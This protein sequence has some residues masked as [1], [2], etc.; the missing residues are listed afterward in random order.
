MSQHKMKTKAIIMIGGSEA[1]IE[2]P[3]TAEFSFDR[4]CRQTLE[5]PGEGPSCT[6]S[7]V[8]IFPPGGDEQNAPSWMFDF[9]EASP[10]FQAD[11]LAAVADSD[12]AAEDMK[13]QEGK[14]RARGL[15]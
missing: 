11:M 14:D 8:R 7:R 1:E 4:G 12:A 3:L 13:F 10:E 5:Q 6:L 2:V 15:E 9:M